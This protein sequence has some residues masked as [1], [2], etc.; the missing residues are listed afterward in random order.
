MGALW[1]LMA[2]LA[3]GSYYLNKKFDISSDW[4][5]VVNYVKDHSFDDKGT[6]QVATISWKSKDD[7]YGAHAVNFL[8]YSV[9]NGQE[10]IYVYDNN[11]PDTETYLY[12]GLD[13]KVY[14]APSST[15][16][17]GIISIDLRSVEKYFSIVGNYFD[18]NDRAMQGKYLSHAIYA[19]KGAISV[20]GASLCRDSDPV[21]PSTCL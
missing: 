19:E 7:K 3:G 20:S 21:Q 8:R 13:G 18:S 5:E 12:K 16:A 11:F 2:M 6:L 17:D 10:R 14:Q 4:S 9:V 1:S 15:F